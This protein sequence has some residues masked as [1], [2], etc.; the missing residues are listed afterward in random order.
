MSEEDEIDETTWFYVL[1]VEDGVVCGSTCDTRLKGNYEVEILIEDI[2]EDQRVELSLGVY[3]QLKNGYMLID[4]DLMS[5]HDFEQSK[6]E[7]DE[8]WRSLGWN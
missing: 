4:K 6:K 1:W 8:L 7:V 2:P 3:F 5:T